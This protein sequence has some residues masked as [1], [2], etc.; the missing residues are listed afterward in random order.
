MSA[1][2][3]VAFDLG[4]LRPL[5][6]EGRRSAAR[7]LR[8][9]KM[10]LKTSGSGGGGGCSSGEGGGGLGESC[11]AR[12]AP[13]GPE[14]T[15]APAGTGPEL[16]SPAVGGGGRT[17]H[18]SSRMCWPL[19]PRAPL[20]SAKRLSLGHFGGLQ[21]S[22]P[23]AKEGRTPGVLGGGR[24]PARRRRARG[25]EGLGGRAGPTE[26]GGERRRS[27]APV[28]EAFAGR[29][30]LASANLRGTRLPLEERAQS[31]CKAAGLV[32]PHLV[33]GT[34]L[35]GAT[36]GSCRSLLP[37]GGRV[38]AG[39][40]AR[41]FFAARHEVMMQLMHLAMHCRDSG[42]GACGPR[43]RPPLGDRF[44]MDYYPRPLEGGP[45]LLPYARRPP[46]APPKNVHLAAPQRNCPQGAGSGT[47]GALCLKH[48][49][50]S[51]PSCRSLG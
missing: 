39:L 46:R 36:L 20:R 22:L 23:R 4:R 9:A 34:L 6:G 19:T 37:L 8:A 40:L 15:S 26:P 35:C 43:M 51:C 31:L 48:W 41:L 13:V 30:L 18:R 33:A 16:W 1:T 12:G 50:P 47:Q 21:L 7:L 49:A 44:L 11:G 3:L 17:G 24:A 2:D 10:R 32:E 5:G 25:R 38:R 14:Q 42:F 45:P 29:A 27:C 28:H